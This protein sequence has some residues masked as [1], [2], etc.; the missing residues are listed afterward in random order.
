MRIILLVAGI[1][2][3]G[4][5][6]EYLVD[7]AGFTWNFLVLAFEFEGCEI[8]IELRRSP[9][10]LGVAVGTA[11]AKASPVRLILLMT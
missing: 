7:M 8:V 1:A 3:C 2:V 4:R 11:K 6:L 10:N 9:A 5:A